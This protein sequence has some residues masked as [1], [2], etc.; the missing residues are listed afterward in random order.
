MAD[1]SRPCRH[2]ATP[3]KSLIFVRWPIEE[4]ELIFVLELGLFVSPKLLDALLWRG[5]ILWWSAAKLVDNKFAHLAT[6]RE[7]RRVGRVLTLNIVAFE[8]GL[9]L[10]R[11]E[12][13]I[14]EFFTARIKIRLLL[15]HRNTPFPSYDQK[16]C[17]SVSVS[18]T[19]PKRVH[20]ALYGIIMIHDYTRETKRLFVTGTFML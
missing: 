12:Q 4:A 14:D 3:Q 19:S 18:T 13:V 11:A 20:I 16:L 5:Q 6:N 10:F 1:S 9:C 8:L 15:F 7:V 17:D 2:S